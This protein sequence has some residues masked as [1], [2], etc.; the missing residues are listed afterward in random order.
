VTGNKKTGIRDYSLDANPLNYSD[1]GFDL[2]GP[3]VHADGEVWNAVQMTIREALIKKYDKQYPHTNKAL[4][5]ACA[6]GRT[7]T[8]AQGPAWN[9]CPGNR[10]YI[11]YQYDAMILQANGAPSMVDMR[12]AEM[13]AVTMRGGADY[14]TVYDAFASRGLGK[15]ASSKSSDDTQPTPSFASNTAANNAHVT[16]NLVD[17]GT[18]KKVKASVFVGI[19]SARCRPVATTL[20]GDEVGPK[21]D[22]LAGKYTFTVQGKGYGI[23]RFTA[24]YKKGQKVTQ[25]F[26]LQPNFASSAYVPSVS[27][28][29]GSARMANVVDDNEDTNGAFTGQPV[30]GR[31]VVVKFKGGEKKTF[32]TIAVSA[33]HHPARTLPEGDTEIEGRF[34]GLRTFDVEASGDG[35]KT[36]RKIY[37]GPGGKGFFPSD[38]PRPVAPDLVIRGVTLPKPVTADAVRL[39]I[40]SSACTGGSDFNR[41]VENDP[42]SESSCL[43]STAAAVNPNN[44]TVTEFQVLRAAS[45]SGAVVVTPGKPTKPPVSAGGGLPATGSSTALALG[46]LGLLGLLAAAWVTRRRVLA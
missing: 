11:Q 38:A 20:G 41:E 39:V 34:L 3:E 28:N 45:A 6:L 37:T 18:G 8:G 5:I 30:A 4:Q 29:A 43:T 17:A 23:Q 33:L 35:G 42:I 22:L 46:G 12:D 2:T 27:G 10:R 14:N 19:F 32:Q 44:V 31:Q 9:K 21:A 24:T 13:I 16:F 1:V 15:G 36:W 7:T 26:K 40:R 25:T